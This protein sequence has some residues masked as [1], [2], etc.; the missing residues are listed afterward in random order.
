M[1][2]NIT[3]KLNKWL[4]VRSFKVQLTQIMVSRIYY[5]IICCERILQYENVYEII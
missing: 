2:H 5:N 1:F 4:S 3:Y